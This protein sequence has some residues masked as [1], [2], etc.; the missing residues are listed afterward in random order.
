MQKADEIAYL[1]L[2]LGGQGVKALPDLFLFRHI[3]PKQI[4]SNEKT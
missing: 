4:Q 3:D 1:P 2:R